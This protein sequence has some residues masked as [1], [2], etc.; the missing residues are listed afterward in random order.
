M[1]P[2]MNFLAHYCMGYD[3]GKDGMNFETT[4]RICAMIPNYSVE[5]IQRMLKTQQKY[6]R[7]DALLLRDPRIVLP[8]LPENRQEINFQSFLEFLFP[9]Y[10]VPFLNNL[11]HNWNFRQAVINI[12]NGKAWNWR[13]EPEEEISDRPPSSFECPPSSPPLI[14]LD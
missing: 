9:P 4:Q 8:Q 12:L 7:E 3:L 11:R 6:M 10:E 1:R 13:E 2:L 14:F 5:L